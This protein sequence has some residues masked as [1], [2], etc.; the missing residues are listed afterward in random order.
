MSGLLRFLT[1]AKTSWI[2]LVL[3]ALAAAAL[4]TIAG[5]EESETAPS[6]G[7]PDS[8]ESV[9]VDQLRDEFPSADGTSALLVFAAEDG[10]LD[11]DTLARINEN[12]TG[13][14]ADISSDGFVPPAQVSEDGTVALVVVPLEPESDVA[15]QRERAEELRDAASASIRGNKHLARVGAPSIRAFEGEMLRLLSEFNSRPDSVPPN[16]NAKDPA[17]AAQ[18]LALIGVAYLLAGSRQSS[19]R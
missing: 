14:L 2:M 19:T 3:A 13:E 12:A 16:S 7:L 1:S 9:Q 17:V 11:A 8:A 15:A 10:K 5:G 6:V 4:F 18:L